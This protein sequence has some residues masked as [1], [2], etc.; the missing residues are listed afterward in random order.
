LLEVNGVRVAVAS[1][2]AQV[3][4]QSMFRH[5]GI[6]PA[7]ERIIAL[8]SSVHF[9]AD[10]QDMASAVLVVA[11][12]GPVVADPRLLDFHNLRAGLRAGSKQLS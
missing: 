3:A 7:Q 8:K 10:F 9:R 12:P 4:D 1:R 6:E 2:A 11:A 5:L